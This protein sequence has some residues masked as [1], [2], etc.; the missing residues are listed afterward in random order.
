MINGN[1]HA[2]IYCIRLQLRHPGG[3]VPV[4]H[5]RCNQA[6]RD[7]EGYIGWDTKN[8]CREVWEGLSDSRY[9]SVVCIC[10]LTYVSWVTE[11]N[12]SDSSAI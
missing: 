9:I 11:T 10:R 4:H 3:N 1:K 8:D 6:N 7:G 2:K 5:E 12:R